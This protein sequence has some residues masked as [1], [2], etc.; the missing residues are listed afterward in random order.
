[1][2]C[3]KNK[4]L[5]KQILRPYGD[6]RSTTK[7]GSRYWMRRHMILISKYV[8]NKLNSI[9]KK[10]IKQ[11]IEKMKKRNN[12]IKDNKLYVVTDFTY[13]S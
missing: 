12:D 5:K 4:K 10:I 1:M 8:L 2:F 11:K 13:N 9:E 7:S 6:V 3:S